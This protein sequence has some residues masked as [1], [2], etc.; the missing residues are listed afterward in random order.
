MGV[1]E[2]SRVGCDNVCCN[3]IHVYGTYICS[4]CQKEFKE[5]LKYLGYP[6]ASRDFFD[7]KLLEFLNNGTLIY[8][9]MKRNDQISIDE[10]F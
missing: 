3:Y 4:D 1:C 6:Y 2:C 8:T 9:S 10:Y 5:E 7:D